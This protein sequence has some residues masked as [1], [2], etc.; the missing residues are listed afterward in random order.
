MLPFASLLTLKPLFFTI[1]N[2][3]ETASSENIGL[4]SYY[5]AKAAVNQKQ[6]LDPGWL[7]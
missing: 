1:K 4:P 5:Y 2:L 3:F 6:I 7:S